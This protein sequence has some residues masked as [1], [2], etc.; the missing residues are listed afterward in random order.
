MKYFCKFC[1]LG[2]FEGKW[3]LLGNIKLKRGMYSDLDRTDQNMDILVI[4]DLVLFK[5]M[6]FVI[7]KLGVQ[8]FM[9]FLFRECY[10]T[11]YHVWQRK[12]DF[13][14]AFKDQ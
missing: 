8:T 4:I 10:Q 14:M 9:P 2:V 13:S 3:T 1:G 11:H 7:T 12:C 6:Q 5:I